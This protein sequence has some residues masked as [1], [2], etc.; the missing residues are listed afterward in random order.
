MND[1]AV[2]LVVD[3]TPESL[4]LL[5]VI[6]TKEGYQTR[7]ADSGVLAFE[8]LNNV[9]PDLIL[10]DI[11]MPDMD[12]YEVCRRLKAEQRTVDIPI[13]FISAGNE[14]PKLVEGFKCGAVDF[15]TRPFNTEIH[16]CPV[17]C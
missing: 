15:V 16:Y 12:G 9:L 1:K 6:L 13:I 3:D 17:N 4:K 10:L 7:L 14:T 5:G 8:S 2:I 11:N